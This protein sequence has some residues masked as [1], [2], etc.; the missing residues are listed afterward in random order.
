MNKY[1]RIIHWL[2]TIFWMTVIFVFSAR[3]TLHASAIDWQ[4][5]IVKK[6]AHFIEYFILASLVYFSLKKTSSLPKYVLV[7]FT[8][9]ITIFYAA[10]DEYHQTFVTGREGKVRDVV[11]D[12]IG[13]ISSLLTIIA[14]GL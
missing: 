11:I 4:D 9:T 6:T 3:P 2:P 14:I 13:A 10:T 7:L 8:I 1:R 12:S 5:F